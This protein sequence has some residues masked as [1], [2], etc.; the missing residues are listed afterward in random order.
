MSNFPFLS[1]YNQIID[2]LTQ[3][4][5]SINKGENPQLSALRNRIALD[6]NRHINFLLA[7]S[8]Q[9]FETQ[10]QATASQIKE[11]PKPLTHMFGQPIIID[12][13]PRQLSTDYTKVM[14]EVPEAKEVAAAELQE[15]VDRLYP[16]FRDI[17]TPA[18]LDTYSE[19][20]IRA[21]AMKAGMNVTETKPKK[22]DAR[23]VDRIKDAIKQKAEI[24]KSGDEA[25][26]VEYTISARLS[27]L[28]ADNH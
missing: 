14:R 4:K 11:E 7:Q 17:E 18:L 23:F 21:V 5:E 25:E 9:D 13:Q 8:G 22:V 24:E 3:A 20:D 6:L 12:P 16:Q 28:N 1:D 26:N 2:V 10:A 15:I 19:M 27:D